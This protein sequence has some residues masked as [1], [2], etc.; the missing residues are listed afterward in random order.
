LTPCWAVESA[1]AELA[2]AME[3]MAALKE[4]VKGKTTALELAH[5]ALLGAVRN[6]D[7]E[8][9]PMP[10]FDGDKTTTTT[11]TFDVTGVHEDL[12]PVPDPILTASIAEWD[13]AY[14]KHLADTSVDVLLVTDNIKK[15]LAEHSPEPI[16]TLA[17][18]T[19][20]KTD[21]PVQGY[22]AVKGIGEAAG[23]KLDDAFTAVMAEWMA[24]HP[25]PGSPDDTKDAPTESPADVPHGENWQEVPSESAP[26]EDPP[27]DFE[28]RFPIAVEATPNETF[29]A[30]WHNG[31]I[32]DLLA[33]TIEL[34][35]KRNMLSDGTTPMNKKEKKGFETAV[36]ELTSR[37]DESFT[38]YGTTF[39][40]TAVGSLRVFIQKKA[41]AKLAL[42]GGLE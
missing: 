25:R 19:K 30:D 5:K 24:Q 39:G 17:D 23:D 14:A 28:T 7:Q 12:G 9:A 11:Q 20:L 3:E 10:L 2:D 26:Q 6:G 13:A 41:D 1:E 38:S 37:L 36:G 16:K 21:N 31:L 34:R 22:T 32:K 15:K 35:E 4:R 42:K 40:A 29:D 8:D 33:D 27:V 18:L